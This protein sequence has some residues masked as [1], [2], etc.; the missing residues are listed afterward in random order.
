MTRITM[1]GEDGDLVAAR[2]ETDSGIDDQPLSTSNAQVW[3][4][5]DDALL[6]RHCWSGNRQLI[7]PDAP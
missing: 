7:V 4:E 6:L 2:L 3:V 5:E 1:R